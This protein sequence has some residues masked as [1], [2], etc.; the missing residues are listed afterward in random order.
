VR[1]LDDVDHFLA[2]VGQPET[3]ADLDGRINLARLIQRP[4]CLRIL[5]LVLVRDD[6][7][8]G[9]NDHAPVRTIELRFQRL[10]GLVILPRGGGEGVFQGRVDTVRLDR[11]FIGQRFDVFVV[12][13]R[14]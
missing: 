7:F 6:L 1:I 9:V 12:E 3:P 13:H 8:D 2:D 4:L 11:L 14:A 10:A 5:D